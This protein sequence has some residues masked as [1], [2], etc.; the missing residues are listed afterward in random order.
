MR[1]P[2]FNWASR[3]MT[4]QEKQIYDALVAYMARIRGA[5]EANQREHVR[6][7]TQWQD[8]GGR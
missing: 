5:L 4:P 6:I 2:R 1:Y 7:A 3:K 8:D